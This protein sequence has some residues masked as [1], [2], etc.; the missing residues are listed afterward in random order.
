MAELVPV[1]SQDKITIVTLQDPPINALGGAMRQSLFDIFETLPE[2]DQAVVIIGAG[3]VFCGGVDL[4]ELEPQK[5]VPSF[6]ELMDKVESCERPVVAALHGRATGGGLELAMACHYRVSQQGTQV[7]QPEVTLGFPPGGGAT[8]RLPRLIGF[9]NALR[10]LVSGGLITDTQA[11]SQGLID[12]RAKGALLPFAVDYA[13]DLIAKGEGPRRTRDMREMLRDGVA[14][15][16]AIAK[17]HEVYE[18]RAF[19]APSH[20]I[21]CVEAALLLPF[22]AGLA[23]EQAVFEDCISSEQSRALRHMLSAERKARQIPEAKGLSARPILKVGVIG[24]GKRA[25]DQMVTLIQAGLHVTYAGPS[26]STLPSL[27]ETWLTA[28]MKA[29]RLSEDQ[30]NKARERFQGPVPPA[31]LSDVDLVIDAAPD[32]E[33]GYASIQKE[34]GALLA[35]ARGATDLGKIEDGAAAVVL[36]FG[37]PI[38][39]SDLL[40]LGKGPETSVE[41]LY[42]MASL[43][44]RLNKQIVICNDARVDLSVWMLGVWCLAAETCLRDGASPYQI[45]AAMR[46]MGCKRGPY[47]LLDL[48]GL[49][50]L[51]ARMPARTPAIKPLPGLM[52]ALREAGQVGQS[53]REGVYLYDKEHP[54]GREDPAIV[55]LTAQLRARRGLPERKISDRAI[56]RRCVIAMAN[57]AIRLRTEGIVRHATDIDVVLH[58]GLGFPRWGGGPVFL[59]D[60]GGLLALRR[61]LRRLADHD[62]YIWDPAPLLGELIK[63]GIALSEA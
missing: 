25:F 15:Q 6:Q 40:V 39:Q 19:D 29:G 61:D 23:F 8:Q 51:A 47:Q 33:S 60:E 21:D 20:I 55:E 12:A 22:D 59:A 34:P 63:N 9:D 57:E 13:K 30:V 3:D 56:Q 36:S 54:D 49:N 5:G 53:G 1:T 58:H 32:S 2:D 38:A 14:N 16:A 50:S 35:V 43:A 31:A 10:M 11:I 24:E 4:R 41:T 17:F 42:R 48:A 46:A 52:D 37:I 45:D 26:E 44:M 27:L 62:P 18:D 28:A 7:G